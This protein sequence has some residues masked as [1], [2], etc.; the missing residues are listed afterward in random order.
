MKHKPITNS[1]KSTQPRKPIKAP[2]LQKEF[3]LARHLPPKL[4]VQVR[5]YMVP[6]G[7]TVTDHKGRTL[8]VYINS[9]FVDKKIKRP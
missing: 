6:T 2:K 9:R 8:P 3:A 1:N 7:Q 4:R 5:P